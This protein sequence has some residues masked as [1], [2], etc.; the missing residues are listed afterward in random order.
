MCNIGL[1]VVTLLCVL[2]GLLASPTATT[3][4]KRAT[5]TPA[6]AGSASTDDVP[7][8]AAAIKSCVSSHFLV[9]FGDSADRSTLFCPAAGKQW[10][11]RDSGW[12]DVSNSLYPVFRWMHK[13]RFSSGGHFEDVG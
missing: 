1:V 10:H 4:A 8:I 11:H 12:Q 5:C 6:S 3:L 9:S 2:P 7:A 13:L